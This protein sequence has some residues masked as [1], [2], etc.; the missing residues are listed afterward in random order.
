MILRR[1]AVALALVVV[2]TVGAALLYA[3]RS[4]LAPA[5]PRR[6][7]VSQAAVARGS[8]LAAIGNCI[9]CHTKDDTA[10]Y[11]GGR[12]IETPFGRI[13]STNITPD[14]DTGIGHWSKDAFV[15][16]VREGVSADGHHL[17]PAFPYDHMAKATEDDIGDVYAFLSTRRAILAAPPPNDLPFPYNVRM[18][19]AGWKLLYMDGSTYR[20]VPVKSQ[21]WNRGAYLVE[22]LAHCG[23]CHTPRNAMGGEIKAQAYGGGT[24]EGWIAP[25]LNADT[26][27][28]APWTA[29][30]LYNYLRHG[31]DSM[32]G[33]ATGPMAPVIHNLEAVPDADVRAMAVYVADIA[34]AA[35][36]AD[37]TVAISRAK[38]A[39]AKASGPGAAIYAG[40]CA[41]CHGDA[42]R[43]PIDPA[44]NLALSSTLRLN[45]PANVVQIVRDG[46]T[47]PVRSLGSSMPPFGAA[48]T[49]KQTQTSDLLAYLR[50]TFTDKPPFDRLD[51]TIARFRRGS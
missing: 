19:V 6:T 44:L 3:W 12:P 34:A 36:P 18:L 22:G 17:Y 42:G 47:P 35:K 40:A 24:T 49:E 1:V 30:R 51:D 5:D 9:T 27:A 28:A 26:P 32:H 25:A 10:P 45:D 23:A 38:D 37:T 41:G 4:P 8:A 31:S 33:T 43:M 48:L 39:V 14:G 13:Y 7:P 46:I 11:A 20:P 29:D 16:A 15:R 50:A 21:E 2:A